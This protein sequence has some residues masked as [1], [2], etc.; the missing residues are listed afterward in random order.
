MERKPNALV[1]KL[2]RQTSAFYDDAYHTL[3]TRGEVDKSWAAICHAKSALFNAEAFYKQGLVDIEEKEY[4]TAVA[5]LKAAYNAIQRAAEVGQG[6][7]LDV[8]VCLCGRKGGILTS[9]FQTC[10]CPILITSPR[11]MNAKK[12][13]FL[14]SSLKCKPSP[15]N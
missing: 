1:A 13:S 11:L 15:Q 9:I 12:N 8:K 14:P 5:R 2:A 7:K 6:V 10:L 4:G 3:I